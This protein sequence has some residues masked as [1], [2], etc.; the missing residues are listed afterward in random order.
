MCITETNIKIQHILILLYLKVI[1]YMNVHP[2]N[3][4]DITNHSYN[5]VALAKGKYQFLLYKFQ[6][7]EN[8]YFP[9][10]KATL[11]SEWFVIKLLICSH[12]HVVFVSECKH[13]LIYVIHIWN[14]W[15]QN[16]SVYNSFSSWSIWNMKVH[17]R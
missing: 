17:S 9:L 2:W 7:M 10:A 4:I 5:K 3:I 11:L 15:F 13:S 8:I 1:T 14:I 16:S 12:Y 6:K